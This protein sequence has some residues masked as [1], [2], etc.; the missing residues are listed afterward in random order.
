M[1]NM[2]K[3]AG[4]AA[5]ALALTQTLQAVPIVGGIGF[6]G[7][8]QLNTSSSAT[9]T[10]VTAWVSPSVLLT[11]G[12]FTTVAN[13]T[14]VNFASGNWYFNSATAPS[15][16]FPIN[17]FWS[18]GNFTFQL[19]SSYIVNQG[20]IPGSTASVTVNGTGIV[21]VTGSNPSGYSPT[22]MSWSFTTQ[23]PS[24]GQPASYTFSASTVSV[25]DGGATVM[26][27]GIAL[28]GV[29]LLRKQFTA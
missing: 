18:V 14:P 2:I 24:I 17:S 26:L 27:L 10:A 4:I 13:L 23:D 11:S 29:A 8:V 6:Q 5:V 1:K 20:G 25:P 22:V 15:G 12:A 19:L 16:S 21:S 28:S 7:A 9:A 3:F